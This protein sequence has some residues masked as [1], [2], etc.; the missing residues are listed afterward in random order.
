MN[1]T[2]DREDLISLIKG[3]TPG[4]LIM[5]DPLI[6]VCGNYVGGMADRQYWNGSFDPNITEEQLLNMYMM[7]KKSNL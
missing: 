3:T 2:L 1:V 6:K 7:C 4:Y 5:D